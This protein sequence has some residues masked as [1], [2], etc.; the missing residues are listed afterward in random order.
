MDWLE[1]TYAVPVVP[2]RIEIYE[3][4]NPG[5]VVQVDVA[6]SAT[7]FEQ[8]V[9]TASPAPNDQCPFT[10]TINV[11]GVTQ[12]VNQVTVHLDQTNH[13]G[14]NEIDAVALISQ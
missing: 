8:T 7:G 11:S 5:A 10:L 3:T 12:L 13:T 1:L 4:Y 2:A 9:Y 14:W 6:N